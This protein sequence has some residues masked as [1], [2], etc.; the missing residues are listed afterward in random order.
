VIQPTY[1][2]LTEALAEIWFEWRRQKLPLYLFLLLS[3]N[4]AIAPAVQAGTGDTFSRGQA[5]ALGGL[6]LVTVALSVYLFT[7]MFQPEKF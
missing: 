1:L 5:Y 7:V 6:G 2:Q 4:L 3:L